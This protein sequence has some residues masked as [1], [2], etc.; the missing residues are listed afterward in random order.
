MFVLKH[1]ESEAIRFS[2]SPQ[3]K[4]HIFFLANFI[5]TESYKWIHV[6]HMDPCIYM[7][8]FSPRYWQLREDW[9]Q[10]ASHRDEHGV[11]HT[12]HARCMMNDLSMP[13]QHFLAS[14]VLGAKVTHEPLA[15]TFRRRR[16]RRGRRRQVNTRVRRNT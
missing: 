10:Q 16:N 14:E 8:T 2:S 15:V 4:P 13:L 9:K 6:A 5:S 12:V 7:P 3:K 11:Y 1:V